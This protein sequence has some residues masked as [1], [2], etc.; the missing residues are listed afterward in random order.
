MSSD[1]KRD[2]TQLGKIIEFL[3][4]SRVVDVNEYAKNEFGN[5]ADFIVDRLMHLARCNWNIETALSVFQEITDE[6]E[7]AHLPQ[8]AFDRKEFSRFVYATFSPSNDEFI[9]MFGFPPVYDK[10][11]VTTIPQ[12]E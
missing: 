4:R 7:I 8:V 12:P 11:F 1:E 2:V 5:S 6:Y 10:E 9:E 3:Y